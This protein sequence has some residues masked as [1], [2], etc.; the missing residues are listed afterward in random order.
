[1]IHY[2]SDYTPFKVIIK[3][4]SI[5]HVCGCEIPHP[6]SCPQGPGIL[7]TLHLGIISSPG[8][9]PKTSHVRALPS[10][11][12]RQWPEN[13]FQKQPLSRDGIGGGG[14]GERNNNSFSAVAFSIS[15]I[16]AVPIFSP[17]SAI[18]FFF[19]W[20]CKLKLQCGKVV[21]SQCC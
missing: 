13:W 2:F 19:L 3:I 15:G 1:M 21:V 9:I 20:L 18:F 8:P 5:F 11:F 14:C 4:W 10:Q 6:L 17:S 16:P 7:G 12:Q